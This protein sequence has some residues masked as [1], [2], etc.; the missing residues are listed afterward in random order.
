MFRVGETVRWRRGLNDA[1]P[2]VGV[3]TDVATHSVQC[4]GNGWMSPGLLERVDGDISTAA[5]LA[6]AAI[7]ALGAM[8]V[9]RDGLAEVVVMQC[10]LIG[11]LQTP[12]PTEWRAKLDRLLAYHLKAVTGSETPELGD[13]TLAALVRHIRGY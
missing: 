7:E 11:T 1:S 6:G 8:Q 5:E 3:V 2:W 12:E 13:T 4:D 10:D 9:E